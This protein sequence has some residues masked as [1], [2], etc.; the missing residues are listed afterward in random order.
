MILWVSL[1][2]VLSIICA[3]FCVMSCRAIVYQMANNYNSAFYLVMQKKPI[4]CKIGGREVR[5]STVALFAEYHSW[6][7]SYLYLY[8]VVPLAVSGEWWSEMLC[9]WLS[10]MFSWQKHV[11]SLSFEHGEE[12]RTGKLL[13]PDRCVWFLFLSLLCHVKI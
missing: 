9:S 3:L 1:Y 2:R 8:S 10:D 11:D 12:F 7:I 5:K 4:T 13:N 6:K